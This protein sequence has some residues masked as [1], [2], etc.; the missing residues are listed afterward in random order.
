MG[1]IILFDIIERETQKAILFVRDE[2]VAWIP[3][4]CIESLDKRGGKAE[5]EDSFEVIW[6]SEDSLKTYSKAEKEIVVTK[7]NENE[8][9]EYL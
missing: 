3:K 4:R 6:K 7:N 1:Y 5:V 9:W 8:L 2:E